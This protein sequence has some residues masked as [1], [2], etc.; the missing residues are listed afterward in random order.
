MRIR[1]LLVL[2]IVWVVAAGCDRNVEP[3]V[4]GE[5]PEQPDLSRIF[6]A[7]AEKSARAAAP[8]SGPM[9]GRGA[10]PIGGSG[11]PIAG[12]VE[13]AEE[14]AERVPPGAVLF[15]I[16]RRGEAGPP[17]AVKRVPSPRFPFDF[18]IGPAD[19]MVEAV[20]FTGPLQITARLDADGNAGTRDPGDLEGQLAEAVD[21]GAEG[22]T[23]VLEA[24]Q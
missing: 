12:R 16:A 8:R 7:G 24:V 5:K 2:A 11:G 15:L 3:F 10:P 20:P 13:V 17:T 6:P 4:P 18:S 21:P 14:L 22:L 23:I 9:G 19:R 1:T